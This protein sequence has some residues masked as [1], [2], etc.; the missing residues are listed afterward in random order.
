MHPLVQSLE[1]IKDSELDKKI[2]ELTN[3]YWMARSPDIREQ[4]AM[5][6]EAYNSELS[7]RR[8]RSWQKQQEKMDADL[9]KLIKIDK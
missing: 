8:L 6:L 9:G 4:I 1:D 3:K 7:D 2:Q 5:V